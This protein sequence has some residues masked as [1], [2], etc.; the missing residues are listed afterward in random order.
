MLGVGAPKA[1]LEKK[2]PGPIPYSGQEVSSSSPLLMQVCQP[3]GDGIWGLWQSQGPA[4]L[5]GQVASLL[6]IR[7]CPADVMAKL[8]EADNRGGA[9]THPPGKRLE[10]KWLRC[11]VAYF[12]LFPFL[13]GV[14]FLCQ[15]L[16]YKLT[17]I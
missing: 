16:T 6:E 17:K 7:V 1:Y 12:A 8:V 9:S 2:Q 15:M 13:L 3:Q 14:M 10:P 11:Y 5:L 4:A